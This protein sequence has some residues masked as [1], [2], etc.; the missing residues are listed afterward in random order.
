MQS[1][2]YPR[3]SRISSGLRV[4]TNLVRKRNADCQNPAQRQHSRP[5]P[6][7]Y[8]ALRTADLFRLLL[9]AAIWGASFLFMRIAAPVLGSMPT[10]FFRASFGALGLL[11]LLVLLRSD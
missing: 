10:A 5:H 11:A 7:G 6:D 3:S 8:T 4:G 2:D 1:G 9:L